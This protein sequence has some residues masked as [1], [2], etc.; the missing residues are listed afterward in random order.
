[1]IIVATKYA[2]A[3][4]CSVV[5]PS[6]AFVVLALEA[7]EGVNVCIFGQE[8]EASCSIDLTCDML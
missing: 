8:L 7:G 5:F 6:I 3:M 2:A 1:M 4:R